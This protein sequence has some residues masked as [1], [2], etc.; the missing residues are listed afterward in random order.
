MRWSP[1]LTNPVVWIAAALIAIVAIA[2]RFDLGDTLS[3]ENLHAYRADLRIWVDGNGA[4][5]ALA[6]VAAYIVATTVA[7]PGIAVLT[8]LGGFL[9]GWSL[10]AAL[11]VVGATL[12]AITIFLFARGLFGPHAIARFGAPGERLAACL[13]RDAGPYLLA[14][15]LVPV[16]PFFLINLV[17]ALVGVP[18]RTYAITT[19]LG[20]IP[21]TVVYALAGSGLGTMLDRG[22]TI[23]PASVLTPEVIAGLLGLSALALAAIPVRRWAER[24]VAARGEGE[25]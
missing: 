4:L 1:L 17:S 11:T 16:F 2:Q 10:G 25:G 20:I 13:R 5:A 22:G 7:M 14:L 21:A 9:F 18:L 12:G 24:R 15:R 23:T 19:L 3:A 6:Y 8:M